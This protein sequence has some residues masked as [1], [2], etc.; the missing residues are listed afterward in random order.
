MKQILDQIASCI[1]CCRQILINTVSVIYINLYNG[2]LRVS[3]L[4]S[5][6]YENRGLS[7]QFY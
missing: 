2:G 3:A 5:I 4:G 6:E 7:L 1:F